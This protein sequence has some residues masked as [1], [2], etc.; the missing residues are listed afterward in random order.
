MLDQT[1]TLAE[2]HL[3]S[4]AV[5]GRE[6]ER[7]EGGAAGET[8][9]GGGDNGAAKKGIASYTVDELLKLACSIQVSLSLWLSNV[10]VS[11]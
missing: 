2:E 8:E 9:G 5:C 3:K 6:R 10:S 1:L 4:L 7:E 11:M